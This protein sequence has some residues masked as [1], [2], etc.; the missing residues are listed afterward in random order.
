ME[1]GISKMLAKVVTGNGHEKLA[2]VFMAQ[3]QQV[4]EPAIVWLISENTDRKT[5]KSLLAD[6]TIDPFKVKIGPCLDQAEWEE[7]QMIIQGAKEIRT[8]AVM[9]TL[10]DKNQKRLAARRKK[11]SALK[12]PLVTCSTPEGVLS[13]HLL[14]YFYMKEQELRAAKESTPTCKDCARQDE[15]KAIV[16][17][18]GVTYCKSKDTH[19][20]LDGETCDEFLADKQKTL[21]EKPK[22]LA[23]TV[24]DLYV[25]NADLASQKD[26]L[27]LAHQE[28]LELAKNCPKCEENCKVVDA[29]LKENAVLRDHNASLVR[30]KERMLSEIQ[31]H[32]LESEVEGEVIANLQRKVQEQAKEIEEVKTRF[33]KAEN[34]RRINECWHRAVQEERDQLK[35]SN[36]ALETV[37][38]TQKDTIDEQSKSIVEYEAI[39]VGL[40]QKLF[41][42]ERL[43]IPLPIMMVN[44]E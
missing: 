27:K 19:V 35:E 21:Q 38:N 14:D 5:F 41:N 22:N 10:R 34:A 43:N 9:K 25:K 8:A 17:S 20:P 2:L 3:D 16:G 40:A 39:R 42:S 7:I 37:V 15:G 18:V 26:A 31:A 30:G 36:I 11:N 44:T 1:D 23:E 13:P 6:G 28:L 32:C 4:L 24:A 29:T 12:P 33:I